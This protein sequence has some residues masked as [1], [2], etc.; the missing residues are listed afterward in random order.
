MANPVGRPPKLTKAERAEVYSAFERYVDVTPDP[1]I[2]GFVVNDPVALK[3]Y[4]TKHNLTDWEEFSVLKERAVVKQ[5]YYLSY[6]ATVGRLNPAVSIF[7]LKQPQHGYTDRQEVSG[8]DGQSA[9]QLVVVRSKDDK[10]EEG[11]GRTVKL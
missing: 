6:G 9:I 5:E 11:K 1:I 7:R 2:A 10:P 4:V 3:Y 8:P